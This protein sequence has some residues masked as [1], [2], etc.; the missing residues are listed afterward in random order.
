[1][2]FDEKSSQGFFEFTDLEL[3]SRHLNADQRLVCCG[4]IFDPRLNTVLKVELRK[5]VK[6]KYLWGYLNST[7]ALICYIIV[8]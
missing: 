6:C 4:S 1:M 5:S 8:Y 7:F 2:H 3:I